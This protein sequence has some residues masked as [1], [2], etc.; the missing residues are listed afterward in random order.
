MHA[1]YFKLPAQNA[2]PQQ[3][4]RELRR[5]GHQEHEFELISPDEEYLRNTADNVAVQMREAGMKVK[6]TVIPGGSFWANWD[7]YAFSITNWL[8]RPLGVQVL[9]LAYRSGEAWNETAYSNPEFDQKLAQA[10][11]VPNADQRRVLMEDV[12]KILQDS[13]IIVQPYWRSLY[14]H[15]SSRVKNY[16]MHQSSEQQFDDTYLEA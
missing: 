6:R 1:E 9:A 10:L 14:C 4:Q 15:I 11:S 2:N 7:K 16:A 12:E 13:G 5:S 3:A 8:P